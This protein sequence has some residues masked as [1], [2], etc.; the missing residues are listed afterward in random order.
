[1]GCGHV[2][3]DE[4]DVHASVV[5]ARVMEEMMERPAKA[6]RLIYRHGGH[7]RHGGLI[8]SPFSVLVHVLHVTKTVSAKIYLLF[9]LIFMLHRRP[10][11]TI[12]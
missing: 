9:L 8:V 6:T 4:G 7:G 5:P 10:F 12:I 3:D 11:R 1:M 2:E